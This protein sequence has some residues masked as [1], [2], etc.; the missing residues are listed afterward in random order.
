MTHMSEKEKILTLLSDFIAQRPGLEP[1]N[2][3]SGWNDTRG[4]AAYRSESRMITRQRHDAETL[5][6]YVAI[7]DSI[8]ADM[9]REGFRAYSG[10][11]TLTDLEGGKLRLDY[12]AGQYFPT[13]YRAAVCA[14][15]SQ[16]IWHWTREHCM[17]S[18]I[19]R[20]GDS[21]YPHANG[22]RNEQS[23]G[24]WLRSHLRREFGATMQR[25]WFD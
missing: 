2:Y 14:V 17:P 13:E 18:K 16:A 22:G 1:G 8:T 4:R 7:R 11:L 9:L 19:V 23:G 12:C 15:L 10:R 3:I 25:R 21:F 6:R 20:N 5:L 24:D